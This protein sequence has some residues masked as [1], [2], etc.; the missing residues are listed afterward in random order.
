MA[1]LNES[2]KILLTSAQYENDVVR[3]LHEVCKALESNEKPDL[4]LLAE[5]CSEEKYKK[6]VE[7]LCK[8]KEVPLMRVE[9][10]AQLGEWVGLCQYD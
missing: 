3:G 6:F 7:L 4:C 1:D 5:D 2:L 9:K 10:R 8:E